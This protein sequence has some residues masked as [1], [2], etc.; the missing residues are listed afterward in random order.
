MGI[1]VTLISIL[2][3][4]YVA[5]AVLVTELVIAGRDGGADSAPGVRRAFKSLVPIALMDLTGDAAVGVRL[6]NRS[7][8]KLLGLFAGKN[9]VKLSLL[10]NFLINLKR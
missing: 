8:P 4:T 10:L 5:L 3:G 2:V 1:R 9:R 6:F 7:V